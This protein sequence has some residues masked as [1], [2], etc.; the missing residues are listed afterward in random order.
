V[1][2]LLADEFYDQQIERMSGLPRYP[3][4]PEAQ[5]ELRRALRRISE[6]DGKFIMRLIS[7]V[8]DTDERCPTPAELLRRANGMQRP[9]VIAGNPDCQ[10][11]NG[12]G[13]VSVTRPVSIGG[14][15]E[16]EADFARPCKC[17]VK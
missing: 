13:W 9:K 15:R 8:V 6:T 14:L 11:C 17:R 10:V 3:M 16:Y 2:K 5:K 4:I 7:D 1:K 12:S